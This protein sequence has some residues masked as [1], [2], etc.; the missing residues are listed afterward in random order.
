[1]A[2]PVAVEI[3][4]YPAFA[5]RV[6]DTV[7]FAVAAL[8]EI[9]DIVSRLDR[10]AQ[11]PSGP[12]CVDHFWQGIVDLAVREHEPVTVVVDDDA[13][14]QGFQHIDQILS[15]LFRLTLPLLHLSDVEQRAGNVAFAAIG[16]DEILANDP[17]AGPPA[18]V[19]ILFDLVGLAS[20]QNLAFAF[21]EVGG[22]GLRYE[23]ARRLANHLRRLD[24]KRAGKRLVGQHE[25][26]RC[27]LDEH[28]VRHA[29]DDSFGQPGL[30]QSVGEIAF[31]ILQ[32]G[33]VV[34]G[35]QALA[36]R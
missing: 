29:V 4:R 33:D 26:Q 32:F 3:T 14:R 10:L 22:L 19:D 17:R 34:I 11:R 31:A 2:L 13:G 7:K 6:V 25:P 8:A 24:P 27:I 36:A 21:L 12:H 20:S 23:R 16:L 30:F 28:R 1:M 9:A 5:I 35:D 18:L 15:C